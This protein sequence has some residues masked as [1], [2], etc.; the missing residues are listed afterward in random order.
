MAPAGRYDSSAGLLVLESARP[1]RTAA[2]PPPRDAREVL[3]DAL[4][5]LEGDAGP[6]VHERRSTARPRVPRAADEVGGV[7]GVI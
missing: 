2:A 3:R 6:V 7:P 4:A 1:R 5:G